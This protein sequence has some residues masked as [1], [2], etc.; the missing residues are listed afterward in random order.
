MQ[1]APSAD[2]VD[3]DGSRTIRN[4]EDTRS[5]LM[6]ALKRPSPIRLNCSAVDEADLSFLQLLFSARK[7]AEDAGK[8]LTLSH[9]ASAPFLA[10]ASR[11][12]FATAPCAFGGKDSYWLIKEDGHGQENSR[13]G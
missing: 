12:G 4:A 5:L 3:L 9:P 13:R 6:E 8:T 2:S 10:A 1:E 11:A 7:S